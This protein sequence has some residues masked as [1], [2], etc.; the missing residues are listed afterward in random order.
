MQYGTLKADGMPVDSS[1]TWDDEYNEK[2][3]IDKE[4]SPEV[5][6]MGKSLAMKV[7]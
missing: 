6:E 5:M 1:T 2:E 4:E 3:K 7:E